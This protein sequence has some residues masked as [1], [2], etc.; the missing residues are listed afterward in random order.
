MFDWESDESFTGAF[1]NGRAVARIKDKYGNINYGYT[2]RTGEM[3]I[4]AEW[5]D[6]E[7][8]AGGLAAV[9]R[10]SKYGFID[11]SGE[12][13]VPIEYDDAGFLWFSE[14]N[15]SPE[16][17]R[18]CYLRQGTEVGIFENPYFVEQKDTQD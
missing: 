17:G 12:I 13:V 15:S 3:V 14:A 18:L 8:F 7:D 10:R 4:P 16:W 1:S 11:K 5:D 9:R 2:D 6:A